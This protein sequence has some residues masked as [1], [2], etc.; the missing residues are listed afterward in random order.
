VSDGDS[1]DFHRALGVPRHV[2][3]NAAEQQTLHTPAPMGTHNDEIRTPLRGSIDDLLSD[4][5]VFD[6]TV[7]LETRR[8]KPL[9]LSLY[10]RATVL[11]PTLK[12][13]GIAC[14]HLGGRRERDRLDD[15]QHQ[16]PVESL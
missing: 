15:M 4:V 7:R 14:R 6:C 2:F 12:L 9:S 13:R 1:H 3:R 11:Y 16:L 5:T 8:A 10:Q